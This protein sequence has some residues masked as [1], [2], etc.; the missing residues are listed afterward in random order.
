MLSVVWMFA[1]GPCDV[2]VELK[3]PDCQLRNFVKRLSRCKG[4]SACGQNRDSFVPVPAERPVGRD[5]T[6]TQTSVT[7]IAV[8][9]AE[10]RADH[11]RGVEQR[12]A[13]LNWQGTLVNEPVD[14]LLEI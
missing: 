6:L 13:F 12:G 1:C 3:L 2:D 4:Q 5:V 8:S 14:V 10:R 7:R 11:R 9:T